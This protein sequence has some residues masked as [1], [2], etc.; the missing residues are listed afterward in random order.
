MEEEEEE[1]EEAVGGG[2]VDAT[3]TPR[4]AR[5]DLILE[6]VTPLW[7]KKSSKRGRVAR[8]SRS[9]TVKHSAPCKPFT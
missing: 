5:A 7:P 2:G 9:A 6:A 8:I 4:L 3:R 1:E